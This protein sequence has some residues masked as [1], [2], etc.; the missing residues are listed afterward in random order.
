MFPAFQK[1]IHFIHLSVNLHNIVGETED[2]GDDVVA[3]SQVVW[4]TRSMWDV[5]YDFY[6][7]P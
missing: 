5:D 1:L 2:L 3:C 7:A 4:D 6:S